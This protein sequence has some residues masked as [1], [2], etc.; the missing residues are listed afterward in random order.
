LDP[1]WYA[2]KHSKGK[3]SVGA[4]AEE[5]EARLVTCIRASPEKSI[6]VR[7]ESTAVV[8]VLVSEDVEALRRVVDVSISREFGEGERVSIS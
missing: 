7:R 2:R 6:E 4:S 1:Y 8:D 5:I 3:R